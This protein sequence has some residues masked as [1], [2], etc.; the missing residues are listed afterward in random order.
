MNNKKTEIV[1]LL[2]CSGSMNLIKSDMEGSLFTLLQNQKQ[3]PDNCKVT[4]ARFNSKFELVFSNVPI[5]CVEE[6]KIHPS[7]GTALLDSLGTLINEVGERLFKT[8]LSDRPEKVIFVVI[9]DGQENASTKFKAETIAEMIEHQEKKYSWDF[10]YLGANQ[11]AF[12]VA[13]TTGISLKN[14]V[15]Y[16][17]SK[18]GLETMSSVLSE[19]ISRLRSGGVRGQS[20][21]CKYNEALISKDFKDKNG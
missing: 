2:D 3:N 14:A 11:D 4:L 13:S 20:L 18:A 5:E 21:Q 16:Q 17:T 1:I 12:K 10:I 8:V 15:T 19:D 6:I 9:T 7:G